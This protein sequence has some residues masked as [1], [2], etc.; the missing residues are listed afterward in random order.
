MMNLSLKYRRVLITLVCS[1]LPYIGFA[2][3][4]LSVFN[5][6]NF[7]GIQRPSALYGQLIDKADGQIK[8]RTAIIAKLNTK[9]DWQA[10]QKSIKASLLEAI[11]AFPEKTPLNAVI[12]GRIERPD[13]TVEKLYFESMPGY[14]VT[15]GLFIPHKRAA[16][17]PA[18]LYCSGHTPLGFRSPVY[19][20]VILNYV[21]KG[22]VV[23]AFDPVGQGE[24]FQY[25]DT[26]K[27]LGGTDEHS[28]AGA[29]SFISGRS[30]AHYFI[31]DGVRGID[32]LSS[33]PEVD[34]GRIG[35]TGRS[36]GGTQSAYIGAVD[37]RVVA[38]A[39]ECYLTTFDKLLR[40]K[41]PQDA[42]QN[43]MYSLE[44]GIDLADFVELRAPR[45]TLMITTSRDMFSI[46]GA[47]DVY[48]EA[49]K[50]YRAF[51]V[52]DHLSMV[53]DDAGH[54]ST[55]K[56]RQAGYAF[57]QKYLQ[58][59]GDSLEQEVEIFDEKQLY[60]TPH[61]QIQELMHGESVFSLNLK[62]TQSRLKERAAYRV[63][64]P[65]YIKTLSMQVA[66]KI[67]YTAPAPSRDV[68]FSGRLHRPGYAIEKYLVKGEGTYYL[69]VLWFKPD[70]S[71]GQAVIVFHED[72]KAEAA[73]PEGLADRLAKAGMEVVLPDLSGSGELGNGFIK[74]GD[75]VIDGVPLNLWFSGILT[76]KTLVGLR[77]EEMV[78]LR[79]FVKKKKA[80]GAIAAVAIGSPGS[81]LLHAEALSPSFDR[82]ALIQ[83]QISF[84][85]VV[86]QRVYQ[87]KWVMSSVPAAL[88]LYDLP[89]LAASLV[90]KPLLILNPLDAT[91]KQVRQ[92][93]AERIYGKAP[94][95][96]A[97]D[98]TVRSGLEVN[99][100][101]TMVMNWLIK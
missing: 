13:F 92:S 7:D 83:S 41:G 3:E 18:I 60:V 94:V 1:S 42:E 12:T 95:N 34:P 20:R 44:K 71:T 9:S 68:I 66:A 75:S 19:Q 25:K 90:G 6:W 79:N 96:R 85:S 16:K 31:W 2:Q 70:K 57:F 37:N 77:A 43:L 47:M 88:P 4:D 48:A 38:A 62:Y 23:L 98:L 22:F 21:K 30:A 49:R 61:G 45:P 58:N 80:T 55:L 54:E 40:S 72:G 87:P 63:E 91:G 53:T 56:N 8:K 97:G 26:L 82:L 65:D 11:G 99:Q 84:E 64:H 29:Q 14:Y 17:A 51:G 32:Y 5:Y 67:G 101:D 15:A 59:P 46:Q 89:D 33:R 52:P 50:A 69:P 78:A 10:R 28:F 100:I 36:G 93:E 27:S 86:E 76:H 73:K 81:E 39:P 24:R 35:V 74:G